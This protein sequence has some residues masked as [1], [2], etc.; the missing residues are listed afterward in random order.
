MIEYIYRV[1]SIYIIFLDSLK[2]EVKIMDQLLK[3]IEA[4]KKSN[5]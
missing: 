3:E 2:K 1:H 4:A 5:Y